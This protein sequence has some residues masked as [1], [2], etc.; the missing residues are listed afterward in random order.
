MTLNNVKVFGQNSIRIETEKVIYIDPLYIDQNYNDA[1]FIFITHDHYDH[2]SLDD[3]YK[4]KKQDTLFVI[5]EKMKM[6][7]SQIN[8]DVRNIKYVSP[9]QKYNYGM[10]SF[11][12]VPSYNETKTFHPKSNGWVGY[13]FDLDKKYYVAGDTDD[14]PEIRHIECDVA[15]IPIGGTYTMNYKEAADLTNTM[16]PK[17]VVPVHYGTIVGEKEDGIRFKNL[18]DSSIDCQIMIQ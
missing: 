12:T 4:I 17:V 5:P 18:I 6:K 10:I 14:V 1:D 9:N 2:F 15:F 7:A 3:I 16:K 13:I 11:E 8:T